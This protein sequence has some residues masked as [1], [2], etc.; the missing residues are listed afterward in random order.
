[1]KNIHILPTDKPSRLTKINS[2]LFFG[3]NEREMLSE[4]S[5]DIVAQHI[6]ITSNELF[7]EN[8]WVL[9]TDTSELYKAD[10][11]DVLVDKK[12]IDWYAD[13]NLEVIMTNDPTL[14]ADGVQAIDDVFLEWY[15]KNPTCEFVE[16]KSMNGQLGC[17]LSNHKEAED[18]NGRPVFETRN[19]L[20]ENECLI[21]KRK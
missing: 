1:M 9:N 18:E 13:F 17:V 14:I 16:V 15:V 10:A 11:D 3:K 4:P 7:K 12:D 5:L 19:L 21:L 6:Y 2:T 8:D 20:D